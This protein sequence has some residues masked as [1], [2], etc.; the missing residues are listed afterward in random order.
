MEGVPVEF[1]VAAIL[2]AMMALFPIPET[3]TLPLDSKIQFTA[4]ENSSLSK[5]DKLAIAALSV[6]I[7]FSAMARIVLVSVK[8]MLLIKRTA[9]NSLGL[10]IRLKG[11]LGFVGHE[12]ILK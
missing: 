8:M 1:N 11:A 7:V 9:K 12:S 3:M 6:A 2:V 4:F 5:E 10:C